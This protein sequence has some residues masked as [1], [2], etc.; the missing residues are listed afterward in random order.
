MTTSLLQRRS[1]R[2]ASRSAA[3][4]AAALERI[5]A[6]L[7]A[8]SAEDSA[9]RVLLILVHEVVEARIRSASLEEHARPRAGSRSPSAASPDDYD[10]LVARIREIVTARLPALAAVLVVSRGDDR[11]LVPADT[12]AHFPQATNGGYAGFHPRDSEAAVTHLEDLRAG[13]AEYLLFPST[14]YW[15]L[16][17]YGG[18]TKHL[19]TTARVVHHDRHC[20]IF[21]LDNALEAP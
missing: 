17:Y 4:D 9:L 7:R 21:D 3:M 14:A 10:T 11:L 13:R 6:R 20:L 19:L 12:A 8:T 15:W 18:L 2:R 1:N 5:R 16:D